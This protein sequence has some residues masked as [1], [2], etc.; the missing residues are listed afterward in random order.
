M[1]VCYRKLVDKNG[2]TS[3][4]RDVGKIGRQ[5]SYNHLAGPDMYDLSDFVFFSGVEQADGFKL[6]KCRLQAVVTFKVEDAGEKLEKIIENP[7]W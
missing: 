2:K 3:T 6:F 7:F 5:K 1:W 4:N